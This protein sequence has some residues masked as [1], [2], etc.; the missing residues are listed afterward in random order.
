LSEALFG[1]AQQNKDMSVEEFLMKPIIVGS[2]SLATTD[3]PSSFPNIPVPSTLYAYS[4]IFDK[5]KGSMIARFDMEF[6]LQVNANPFQQGR[7]MLTYLPIGGT[8]SN[9][10]TS[11]SWNAMHKFSPTQRTQLSHVEIDLACQTSVKFTVPFTSIHNGYYVDANSSFEFDAGFIQIIPYVSLSTGSGGSSSAS[12]TL[13]ASLKNVKRAIAV[14]PQSGKAYSKSKSSNSSMQEAQKAGVGPI[15]T[16]AR[17]VSKVAGYLTAVPLLSE[18][19]GPIKWAADIGANVAAVF[20]WSRPLNCEADKKMVTD[21]M[22]NWSHYDAI[23]NSKLLA[24]SIKNEVE[25]LDGFAGTSIDELHFDTFLGINSWFGSFDWSTSRTADAYLYGFQV[26]PDTF[27]YVCNDQH[28]YSVTN[29]TPVSY[30]ATLFG[31]W[32][33]DLIL[34]MKFVKTN[35]HSGRVSVSFAP[36][37]GRLGG[38]TVNLASSSYLNR[39]I[40]DVRECSEYSLTIPY[41]AIDPYTDCYGSNLTGFLDIRV[42]DPLTAPASVNSTITVLLEIRAAAGF[43]FA[44]PT[45]NNITP[46]INTGIAAIAHSGEAYDTDPC[47]KYQSQIGASHYQAPSMAASTSCIGERISS[48]RQMLR[49]PQFYTTAPTLAPVNDYIRIFP[50]ATSVVYSGTSVIAWDGFNCDLVSQ[51]QSMF[52]MQRG[53]MRYKVLAKLTEDLPMSNVVTY[54]SVLNE[55]STSGYMQPIGYGTTDYLGHTIH[56]N[57]PIAGGPF[58][59][60]N[61]GTRSGIEVQIPQYAKTHSRACVDSMM[62][63]ALW[64]EMARGNKNVVLNIVNPMG[65]VLGTNIARCGA[66]DYTLGG[67]VSIPP[68]VSVAPT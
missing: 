18:F 57:Y 1:G 62:N 3:N 25:N 47:Q 6:T 31:R 63:S 16:T 22:Y 58:A 68:M 37:V 9:S 12:Y 11:D 13:W 61:V 41:M 55:G 20:G 50:F 56:D 34:T 33:G 65:L 8:C 44:I 38:P 4:Q 40:I 19:A 26:S 59:I 49:I 60:H 32:R 5:L 21:A 28:G 42:L 39:T 30:M 27:K 23:D 67:F 10:Q 53:G 17:Q 46:I 54:F 36:Y 66:D 15:E 64:T 7:Y 2:G 24:Y 43:E 51:L 45:A 48:L 14:I 35:F 29:Y 52:L